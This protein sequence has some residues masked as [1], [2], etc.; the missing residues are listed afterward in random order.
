MGPWRNEMKRKMSVFFFFFFFVV[1]LI[2]FFFLIIFVVLVLGFGR[3][4][5]HTL[6]PLTFFHKIIIIQ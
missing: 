4:K 2:F 5:N 3:R 6:A 1:F